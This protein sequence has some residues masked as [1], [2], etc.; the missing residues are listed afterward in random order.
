MQSFVNFFDGENIIETDLRGSETV[1]VL[2]VLKAI[3][4]ET[5]IRIVNV[6]RKDVLCVCDLEKILNISQ[7]NASRHLA[8][9]RRARLV[10]SEK[11]A[12]W[13]Y[14]SLNQSLI[15]AHPFLQEI[16]ANELEPVAILRADLDRWKRYR[17]MGGDCL[18]DVN[19]EGE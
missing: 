3:G 16:L 14:F 2:V 19:L 4:D 11:K 13:V 15:D 18:H 5:R 10:T 1:D 17:E 7:S 12:Q 9:L 6:L 8:V